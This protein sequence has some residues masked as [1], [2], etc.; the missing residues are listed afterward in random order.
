MENS[1][2]III[3]HQKEILTNLKNLIQSVA[4]E[5]ETLMK[6]ARSPS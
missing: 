2:K 3:K 4:D 6:H 5:F 1:M